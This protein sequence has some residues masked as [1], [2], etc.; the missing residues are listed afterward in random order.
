MA[1]SIAN[2]IQEFV[3]RGEATSLPE[4][5][6]CGCCSAYHPAKWDGDCRDDNN[7]FDPDMLDINFGWDGWREVEQPDGVVDVRR[8]SKGGLY[9]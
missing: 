5:Y 3:L 2:Q 7:R 1:R 8:F 9:L 4:Y 6:Q